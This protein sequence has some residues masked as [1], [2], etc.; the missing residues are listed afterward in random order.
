MFF[1]SGRES[2]NGQALFK[3]CREANPASYFITN[4]VDI[5]GISLEG[6]ETIGIS[7][8]TSTPGWLIK[9]VED[10]LRGKEGKSF[11]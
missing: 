3:V 11:T 1:V 10:C 6:K 8:A 5:E 7:G 2:S 9:D 4:T